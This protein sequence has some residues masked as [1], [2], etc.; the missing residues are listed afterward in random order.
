M[1]PLALSNNWNA[2]A[3]SP[4]LG[5]TEFNIGFYKQSRLPLCVFCKLKFHLNITLGGL[6]EKN[7]V[8][9]MKKKDEEREAKEKEEKKG[10]REDFKQTE[11][12]EDKVISQLYTC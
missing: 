9:R 12:R 6:N 3:P 4:L 1:Y 11:L 7:G 8:L 2:N 10:E 5:R